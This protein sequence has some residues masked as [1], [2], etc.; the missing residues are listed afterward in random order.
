MSPPNCQDGSHALGTIRA[1]QCIGCGKI[2][3]PQQCVG[4]CQDRKVEMV[5]LHDH[6]AVIAGQAKRIE[7]ALTVLRQIAF[8]T[9]HAGAAERTWA[10]LQQRAQQVLKAMES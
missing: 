8:T 10:A 3:A 9:P 4:V 7:A 1:W 2:E 5:S 6:R